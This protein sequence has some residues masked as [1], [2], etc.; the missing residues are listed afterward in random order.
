MIISNLQA[1]SSLSKDTIHARTIDRMIGS[2][3]Q[4]ARILFK[5][6]ICILEGTAARLNHKVIHQRNKYGVEDGVHEI[7][8][9]FE[10]MDSGWSCL[11]NDLPELSASVHTL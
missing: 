4:P 10:V 5:P 3:Y 2:M 11:N 1:A 7:Q 8:A 6:A 9:P